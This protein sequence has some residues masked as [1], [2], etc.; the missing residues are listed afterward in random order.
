MV[1]FVVI[2]RTDEDFAALRETAKGFKA[3]GARVV[4]FDDVH[5]PDAADLA[6][7]KKESEIASQAGI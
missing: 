7:R 6:L 1:L 2:N 4:M 3:E 5:D